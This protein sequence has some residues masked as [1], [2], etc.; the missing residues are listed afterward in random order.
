MS[1]K[2]E[3]RDGGRDLNRDPITKTPG[4][5]PIGVGVG[6]LA[7]GAAAGAAAGTVFGPVGTLVG[8]AVGVVAGAAIGKGVAE[9]IDPTGEVE[10][11]REA[12][13]ERPYVKAERDYDRD[14]APAYGLGLQAREA[15]RSRGWDDA[16]AGLQQEWES[17]R[18]QSQLDWEDARPAVRD[19]WDRADRTYSL[20]ERSDAYHADEFERAP[21][22]QAEESFDDYRPAYRYGTYARAQYADRPW[23]D[24]LEAELGRDWPTRRGGS[25]LEWD[26]AKSAVREAYTTSGDR[27]TSGGH[28]SGVGGNDDDR[29]R[30]G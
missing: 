20:Y 14:Y 15:D 5:H 3:I 23:D 30:V 9:R 2:D 29:F 6:G 18:Q 26:R 22:R 12:H 13:Q 25:G 8:A 11:W 21:W 10:Y 28:Y 24:T 17:S 1:N 19:A 16:E 27:Y 4:A 7:G